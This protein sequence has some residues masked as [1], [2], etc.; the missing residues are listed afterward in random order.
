MS[1]RDEAVAADDTTTKRDVVVPENVFERIPMIQR[2]LLTDYTQ[3]NIKPIPLHRWE[4]ISTTT[5]YRQNTT[6]ERDEYDWKEK[7]PYVALIGVMK[8]GTT[9]LSEYLFQHPNIANSIKE[10]HFFDTRMDS[11][12]RKG[13]ISQ[14]I[15]RKDYRYR[16]QDYQNRSEGNIG[17]INNKGDGMRILDATPAYLFFSDR[18]PQRMLCV[19]PWVKLLAVL[20]NPVDRAYSQYV[21]GYS[22]GKKDPAVTFDEWIRYDYQILVEL[23]VL[24]DHHHQP[25]QQQTPLSSR[26][27]FDEFFGSQE[28]L[29]GWKIYTKLGLNGGVARGL[30]AMQIQHW[31]QAFQEQG[32]TL[33]LLAVRSEDMKIDSNGTYMKVLDYLQLPQIPLKNYEVITSGKRK[34]KNFD[35]MSDDT[36]E[37]LQT[38]YEP[39]NRKL[40][41]L[42]GEEW[43]GVWEPEV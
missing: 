39:Y 28:Q 25:Q 41:T 27:E 43:K 13:G 22:R 23:G 31:A 21:M 19:C 9:S 34:Y 30:Y 6:D 20:R 10:L 3:F 15:T 7:L 37:F 38:I 5:C 1:L 26:E 29:D 18:I 16:I 12:V 42:L 32:K 33:D 40:A 36:R 2:A 14:S 17:E 11:K 24:R 4:T 8:G 35:A